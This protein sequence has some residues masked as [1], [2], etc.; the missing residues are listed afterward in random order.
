MAVLY[1]MGMALCVC[2]CVSWLV[3]VVIERRVVV[4]WLFFLCVSQ[5]STVQYPIRVEWNVEVLCEL[6]VGEFGMRV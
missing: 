1:V 3:V 2:V 4:L 6:Q 5:Y